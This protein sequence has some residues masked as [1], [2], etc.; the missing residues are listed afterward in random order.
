[1]CMILLFTHLP[2]VQ[3][4]LLSSVY[5]YLL[6]CCFQNL[7]TMLT[8]HFTVINANYRVQE[9]LY[10]MTAV[11]LQ[12]CKCTHPALN[13]GCIVAN[14]CCI[15]A[16]IIVR[17]CH[18]RNVTFK[19]EFCFKY[20]TRNNMAFVLTRSTVV[21]QQNTRSQASALPSIGTVCNRAPCLRNYFILLQY[22]SFCFLVYENVCKTHKILENS[23]KRLESQKY[24]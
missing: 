12:Q 19:G 18:H 13:L 22:S 3:Y 23:V 17:Y 6:Q 2:L 20:E 15:T 21:I 8:F 24:V 9:K 5:I 10:R 1:M 7:P 11:S 16:T 14:F 4:L